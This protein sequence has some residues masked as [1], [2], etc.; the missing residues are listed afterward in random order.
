MEFAD[1]D[2][3]VTKSHLIHQKYLEPVKNY[4]LPHEPSGQPS[5]LQ[6]PKNLMLPR[7]VNKE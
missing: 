2:P 6:T 4:S 5:I 3:E 1:R 7:L